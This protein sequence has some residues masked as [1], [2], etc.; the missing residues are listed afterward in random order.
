MLL[1]SRLAGHMMVYNFPLIVEILPPVMLFSVYIIDTY[2]PL[3]PSDLTQ[4][5]NMVLFLGLHMLT[6]T[7]FHFAF[8]FPD[9]VPLCSL[10]CP[11]HTYSPRKTRM[12]SNAE[13]CLLCS[14]VWDWCALMLQATS[15]SCHSSCP[16][17]CLP[18]SL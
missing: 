5:L 12:S 16:S 18:Y 10:A 2:S 11:G 14:Q 6:T 15:S 4:L 9:R 1:I 13:I 8:V 3:F 17:Y 7:A